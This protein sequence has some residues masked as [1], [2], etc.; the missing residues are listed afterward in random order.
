MDECKPLVVGLTALVLHTS[1][2]TGRKKVVPVS[3]R[4]LV[5]G[6][7]CVAA[8]QLLSPADLC[9]N[10][11][12]LF[13]V[14]GVVRPLTYLGGTRQRMSFNSRNEGSKQW[15]YMVRGLYPHYNSYEYS[16]VT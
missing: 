2:S 10:T 15:V 14:G 3:A 12:P 11:M 6:A 8:S 5:V 7:V 1:G 13:H 16:A 9:C 4:A